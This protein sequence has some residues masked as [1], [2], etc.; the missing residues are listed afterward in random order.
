[1]ILVAGG[2]E[3]VEDGVRLKGLGLEFGVKLAA[4]EEG[5]GGDLTIST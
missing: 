1:V 2:Y 4:E 5:A 3:V